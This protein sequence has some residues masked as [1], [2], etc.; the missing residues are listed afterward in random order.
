[1]DLILINNPSPEWSYMWECIDK[2]PYTKLLT[3]SEALRWQY[4]G[5]LRQDGKI[6]HQFKHGLKE[7]VIASSEHINED[8]FFKIIKLK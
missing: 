8:D 2:H 6:L 1:M 3:E 5:S 7:L 4:T